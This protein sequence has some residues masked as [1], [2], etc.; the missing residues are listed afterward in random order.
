[1]GWQQYIG[2]ATQGGVR[3]VR[4]STC[5]NPPCR[6]PSRISSSS[7][8]SDPRTGGGAPVPTPTPRP[9]NAG[10]GASLLRAF[11][12]KATRKAGEAGWV[13][14]AERQGRRA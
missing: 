10:L 9:I 14:E 2:R 11:L 3:Q 12:A 4:G 1:M 5:S 7:Q 13:D 6:A 8:R